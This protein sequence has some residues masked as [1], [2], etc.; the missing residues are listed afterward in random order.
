MEKQ[1]V[2][3]SKEQELSLPIEKIEKIIQWQQPI[4]IPETSSFVLGV[5]E[6]NEH[7]LPIID[8]NARLYGTETVQHKEMK[9][10]VVQWHDE[11]LGLSVESI[12]GIVN[13]ESAQFEWM[14]N[15]VTVEKDYIEKFIKT[16]SGIVI[17]LDI[18]SLFEGNIMLDKLL[19]ALE[20]SQPKMKET[21][22]DDGSIINSEL[23]DE[24]CWS[25]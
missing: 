5:I 14:D 23:V 11:L 7:V 4:P 24:T 25:K 13:F 17:Q 16:E 8:L 22:E 9:I 3:F 21:K 19:R 2:F 15:E 18:D 10:I 12:K 1:I 20:I 6:H